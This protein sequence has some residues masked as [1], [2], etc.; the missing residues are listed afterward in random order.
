MAVRVCPICDKKMKFAHFCTSCKT[1][2]K[3]PAYWEQ[4]YNLNGEGSRSTEVNQCENHDHTKENAT[5]KVRSNY[6]RISHKNPIQNTV[7]EYGTEARRNIE[8]AGRRGTG[9]KNTFVT[10]ILIYIALQFIIPLMAMFF[11]IFTR[12]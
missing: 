9:K 7:R 8:K 11:S 3:E 6:N 5:G 2:I 1:Y 10:I 12:F 4:D